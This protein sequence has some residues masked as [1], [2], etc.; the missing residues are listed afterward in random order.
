MHTVNAVAADRHNLNCS[1]FFLKMVKCSV[2][3]RGNSRTAPFG[4]A[5]EQ[6]AQ[7]GGGFTVPGGV[8]GPWKCGTEVL[9]MHVD[10]NNYLLELL[11]HCRSLPREAV[12]ALSLEVFKA[13]V[14]DRKS[15]RLNSSHPH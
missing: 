12:D 8:R 11:K 4:Q 14:E 7:G 1:W 3:F 5:V 10:G 9:R 15:T 6:A 2:S 13:R